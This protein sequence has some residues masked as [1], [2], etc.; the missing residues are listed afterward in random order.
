MINLYE[1][2]ANEDA[3]QGIWSYLADDEGIIFN[4]PPAAREEK[5]DGLSQDQ[6]MAVN[7]IKEAHM[8]RTKGNIKDGLAI[9][10]QTLNDPK[11]ADHLDDHIKM[12]L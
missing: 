12:E 5:K 7:L 2:I 4:R 11:M 9:L 3:L 6:E 1:L 10:E 8:L